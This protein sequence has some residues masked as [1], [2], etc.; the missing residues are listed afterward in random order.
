ML[1]D[2]S[3]VRIEIGRGSR[4]VLDVLGRIHTVGTRIDGVSVSE[5]SLEDVFVR[6]T[7]DRLDVSTTSDSALDVAIARRFRGAPTGA[8]R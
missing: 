6:L 3:S 2:G 4:D 8:R 7:G 1:G 5:P